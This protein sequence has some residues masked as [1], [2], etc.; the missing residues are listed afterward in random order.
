M[1]KYKKKDVPKKVNGFTLKHDKKNDLYTIK[2]RQG[3]TIISKPNPESAI[4]WA[5]KDRRYA[6]YEPSIG[7]LASKKMHVKKEDKP[8]N[9]K[10]ISKKI[11]KLNSKLKK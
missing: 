1:E 9:K 5:K 11:M 3:Y 6:K 2:D 7:G 8:I 10:T 4:E